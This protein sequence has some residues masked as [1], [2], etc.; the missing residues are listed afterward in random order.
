[1]LSYI[2]YLFN[3]ILSTFKKSGAKNFITN[4]Y[5]SNKNKDKVKLNFVVLLLDFAPN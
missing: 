2:Y 4:F 5:I 3:S 1:M